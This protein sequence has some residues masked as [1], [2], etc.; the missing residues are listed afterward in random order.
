MASCG[1]QPKGACCDPGNQCMLGCTDNV[2]SGQCST[3]NGTFH[4]GQTCS[5]L[6]GSLRDPDLDPALLV[7]KRPL[8]LAATTTTL[9]SSPNPFTHGEPVT[10]TAIVTPTPPDGESVNFMESSTLLGTG[11]LSGGSA[12]FTTLALQVGTTTVTAIFGGDSNFAPPQN[13]PSQQRGDFSNRRPSF[14]R[15]RRSA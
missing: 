5:Q 1:S 2:T 8:V 6:Q 12:S 9:S 3:V 11:T 4:Q 7:P 15:C 14:V 10:F 13:G